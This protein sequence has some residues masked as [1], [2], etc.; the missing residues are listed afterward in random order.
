MKTFEELTK[1]EL[2]G[3]S[4][5]QVDAYIDLELATEG[6]V[7]PIAIK[8]D[9][10]DYIKT[11]GVL[12]EKD[13]TV[14]EVDG[15]KFLDI[16]TAQKYATFVGTLLQANTNY[17]YYSNDNIHYVIDSKFLTPT[18]SI[19][20]MYSG[21]KY[22]AYKEQIRQIKEKQNKEKKENDNEVESVI[23]YEAIDMIKE[24][25][26]KKIREAID[27]YE[28]IEEVS[29]SYP[30]YFSIT[31]DKEKALQ[32]LYTVYNIQDEEMKN[33]IALKNV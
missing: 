18:V 8:R 4:D 1:K 9:Y 25:I 12:P 22:Q 24:K 21:A 14:Y 5:V 16:E 13:M 17:D 28:K 23:N 10:P 3:L 7:K 20:K 2:T 27:F 11:I 19:T 30:T 6:I 33:E 31:N 26:W 15:Y 29:K 32:T